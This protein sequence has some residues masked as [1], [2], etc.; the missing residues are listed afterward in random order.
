MKYC[1]ATPMTLETIQYRESPLGNCNEKNPIISGII[2][3][4]MIW[5][6]CCLGSIDGI[7]VIFC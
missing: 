5:F 6:D 2:H 3:S 4:I 7:M 1:I